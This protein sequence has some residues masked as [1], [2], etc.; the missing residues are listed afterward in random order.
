MDEN[1]GFVRAPLVWME[2]KM[3]SILDW[4]A[5][6]VFWVGALV[7]F[8]V[9]YQQVFSKTYWESYLFE[10]GTWWNILTSVL[11]FWI[12]SLSIVYSK[13]ILV[14]IKGTHQGTEDGVRQLLVIRKNTSK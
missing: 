6:V 1:V 4:L 13:V 8:L 11:P 2:S 9:L 14:S 10:M 5:L 3:V 7:L 12:V